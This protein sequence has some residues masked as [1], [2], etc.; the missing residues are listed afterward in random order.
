MEYAQICLTEVQENID[1]F[2]PEI[3]ILLSP[4]FNTD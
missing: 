3:G 2:V 4:M 1:P